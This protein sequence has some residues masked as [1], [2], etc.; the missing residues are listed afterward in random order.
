MSCS[1]SRIALR[2]FSHTNYLPETACNYG[3]SQRARPASPSWCSC[4][5]CY[6]ENFRYVPQ[7]LL[8]FQQILFERREFARNICHT[9]VKIGFVK[10]IPTLY[11]RAKRFDKLRSIV[12]PRINVLRVHPSTAGGKPLRVR[13]M[14]HDHHDSDT[15]VIQGLQERRI[16]TY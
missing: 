16:L 8:A 10:S 12:E 4:T 2:E 15:A 13:E 14:M 3:R 6:G 5:S 9:A 1:I 11:I 7:R